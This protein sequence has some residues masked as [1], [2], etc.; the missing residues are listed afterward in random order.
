MCQVILKVH[1]Y[2]KQKINLYTMAQLKSV[3]GYL[4]KNV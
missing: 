2:A 1:I 4:E 3:L